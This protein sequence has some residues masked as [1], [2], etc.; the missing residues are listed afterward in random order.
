MQRRATLQI[1]HGEQRGM[2]HQN[3]L[4]DLEIVGIHRAQERNEQL[5]PFVIVCHDARME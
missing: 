2:I 4:L 1:A 5:V 3:L